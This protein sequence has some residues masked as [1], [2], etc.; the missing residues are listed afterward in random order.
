MLRLGMLACALC[1]LVLS[2]WTA[3]GLRGHWSLL[4]AA[5]LGLSLGLLAAFL[6]P[7]FK[8]RPRAGWGVELGLHE[9]K[10]ARPLSDTPLAIPW[11]QVAHVAR[12]GKRKQQLMVVLDP[13]PGRILVARHLFARRS[14]FDALATEL[15][16]RKP[17]PRLDA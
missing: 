1:A 14:E 10:I 7:Y 13:S 2:A 6:V 17:A 15:T 12:I 4:G 8:L 5:R 16:A 9:L 3:A 11:E